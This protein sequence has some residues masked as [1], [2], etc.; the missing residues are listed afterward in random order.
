MALRILVVDD[1]D[2]VCQGACLILRDRPDWQ[3]CGEAENQGSRRARKSLPARYRARWARSKR[4]KKS[5]KP[6]I[7]TPCLTL[8]I[9]RGLATPAACPFLVHTALVSDILVSLCDP[10]K[11]ATLSERGANPRVRQIAYWLEVRRQQGEDPATVMRESEDERRPVERL[12]I[13]S[14]A[15]LTLRSNKNPRSTIRVIKNRPS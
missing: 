1:H 6:G 2:V 8:R 5:A 11:L 12:Q 7:P 14:S 15:P 13:P 4:P 9:N 3:I 10:A